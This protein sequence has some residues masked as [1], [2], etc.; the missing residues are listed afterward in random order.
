MDVAWMVASVQYQ[1][2]MEFA[3]LWQIS[4]GISVMARLVT[5]TAWSLLG[6]N[7]AGVGLSGAGIS[8]TAS[9]AHTL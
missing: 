2:C 6:L 3:R 4:Y 8:S 7:A 1:R 5:G 9:Q